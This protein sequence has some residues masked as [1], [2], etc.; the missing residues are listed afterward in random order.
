MY[1][2][3][4]RCVPSS[5]NNASAMCRFVCVTFALLLLLF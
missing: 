5:Y 2:L 1:S 4:T 3:L